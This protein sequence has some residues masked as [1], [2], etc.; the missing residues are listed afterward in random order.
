MSIVGLV[1]EEGK[2]RIIAEARYIKIPSSPFAEVVFVLDEKYQ[3]SGIASFLYKM[4]IR[5]A[6]E[7]G[8][9]GFMAEVLLIMESDTQFSFG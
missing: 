9:R 2:G 5:L 7:K 3:Q 6:K 4:L 8:I 1:G